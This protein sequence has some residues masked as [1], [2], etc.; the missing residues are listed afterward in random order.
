MFHVERIAGAMPDLLTVHKELLERRRHVM[1][2]V[3]PGPIEPHYQD[4]EAAVKWLKPEGRWADLGTGAGFPGIVFAALFPGVEL[5]L[6]DSRQKRTVFL[7][8]VLAEART[9]GVRVVQA[10]VEDLPDASYD[11]ILA[12][13]FA[14][15]EELL[16]HARRLLKPGG[17]VVLF[18]QDDAPVPPSPDFQVFHVER[19]RVDGKARKA[20]GLRKAS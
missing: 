16:A 10:R 19:Y 14:P 3:G 11:G 7:E 6:V 12:R 9:P 5:D 1:N 13:A 17:T 4:S 15:P 8:A 2:L 20:V 18:L